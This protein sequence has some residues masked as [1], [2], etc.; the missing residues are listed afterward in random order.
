MQGILINYH[1][2]HCCIVRL[3]AVYHFTHNKVTQQSVALLTHKC[4]YV[5]ISSSFVSHFTEATL[6][7][8]VFSKTQE[9]EVKLGY[10]L[11]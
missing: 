9:S 4:A 8:L 3:I 5:I 11:L 6:S 7:S 2:I 1:S 10:S